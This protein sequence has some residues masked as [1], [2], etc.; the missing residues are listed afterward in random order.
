MVVGFGLLVGFAALV[1]L[2]F[3]GFVG[4]DGFV[5]L[6]AFGLGV[7]VFAGFG[8][9]GFGLLVERDPEGAFVDG[10]GVPWNSFRN[11]SF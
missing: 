1:G 5:T 11:R 4:F 3:V 9:V 8:F 7:D 10:V 2:G 6:V